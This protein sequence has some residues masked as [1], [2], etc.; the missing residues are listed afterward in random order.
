MH[1]GVIQKH[2]SICVTYRIN[3]LEIKG[4]IFH[5][6]GLYHPLDGDNNLKYKL[7]CFLTPNKKKFKEKGTTQIDTAI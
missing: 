5:T 3:A 4:F 7:L 2:F 6:M 1:F